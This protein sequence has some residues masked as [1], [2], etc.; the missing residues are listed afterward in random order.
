MQQELGKD[1]AAKS[2][3]KQVPFQYYRDA[4]TTVRYLVICLFY[5]FLHFSFQS[6][7]LNQNHP[8][9]PCD[10]L[11]GQPLTSTNLTGKK[12]NALANDLNV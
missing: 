9:P 11:A 1:T 5:P 4:S 8:V 10:Q 3:F 7:Y 6:T 12:K 2:G